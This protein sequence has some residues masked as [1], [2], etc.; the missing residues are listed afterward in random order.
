[1]VV[2]ELVYQLSWQAISGRFNA[3]EPK[4]PKRSP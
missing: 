1:M 2:L 4:I 3:D